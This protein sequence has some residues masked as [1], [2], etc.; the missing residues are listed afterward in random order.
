M[1]GAEGR[2]R[3][4]TGSPPPVFETGAST[5]PPLR[6]DTT[7]WPFSQ[8]CKRRPLDRCSKF[9]PASWSGAGRMCTPA[10]VAIPLPIPRPPLVGSAITR[11]FRPQLRPR[12]ESAPT[13]DRQDEWYQPRPNPWLAPLSTSEP[14]CSPRTITVHITRAD[15]TRYESPIRSHRLRRVEAIVGLWAPSE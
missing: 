15:A 8:F 14:P 10:A 3:T 9:L 6:P 11:P 7:I 5:I 2:I 4:D 1:V 13:S 12:G